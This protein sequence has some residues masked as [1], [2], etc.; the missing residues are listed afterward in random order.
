MDVSVAD[1]IFKNPTDVDLID[2]TLTLIVPTSILTSNSII[3]VYSVIRAGLV[4]PSLEY[5]LAYIPASIEGEQSSE[6]IVEC[7]DVVRNY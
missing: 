6:I 3:R 1:L 7:T 2:D 4:D 5:E